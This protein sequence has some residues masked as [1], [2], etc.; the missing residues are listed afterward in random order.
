[1]IHVPGHFG[2]FLQGRIGP[3]GPVALISVP[4]PALG[5]RG[6]TAPRAG[7]NLHGGLLTPALARQMLARLNLRPRGYFALHPLAEPGC[8]TGV[9]TASLVALALL[10]GWRGHPQDLAAACIDVEGASDPLMFVRP[11]RMLWAS[12]QGRCL[13]SLPPVPRFEMIGGL[14]GAPRRTI[15]TDSDFPDIADLVHAWRGTSDL[16]GF[17]TLASESAARTL[18][19]RGPSGDLTAELARRAGALG[20]CIAHTGAARG[21]IFA[22]G[23]V[24]AG[25]AQMLR[26]AG[27]R[28][29]IQ[30]RGGS[31]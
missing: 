13:A 26:D 22:P 17:A 12:R 16:A 10:A 29:V 14:W 15:A 1:M 8:G 30:F 19:L 5:V 21:L 27:L 24:P 28:G 18:A 6:Q 23:C 3:S 11:D 20:Y 9:S 25:A 2:E 4:C 7:L 31:A